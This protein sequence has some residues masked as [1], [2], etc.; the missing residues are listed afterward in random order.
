MTAAN[1]GF[2][3]VRL[4]A[5]I[6]LSGDPRLYHILTICCSSQNEDFCEIEEK[7]DTQQMQDL[8]PF[9]HDPTELCPPNISSKYAPV[10]EST[11]SN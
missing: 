9:I 10:S 5:G 3:P 7:E 2:L 6:Q 11:D 1:I 8:S 4:L